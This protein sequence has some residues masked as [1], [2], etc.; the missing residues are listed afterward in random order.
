MTATNL[1]GSSTHTCTASFTLEE[2]ESGL[3]SGPVE[4]GLCGE[5]TLGEGELEDVVE[6]IEDEADD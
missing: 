2:G 4:V 5:Q 3:E 6:D 1:Q